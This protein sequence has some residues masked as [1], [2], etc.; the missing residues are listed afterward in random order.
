M[1]LY[2]LYCNVCKKKKFFDP[3]YSEYYEENAWMYWTQS[4]ITAFCLLCHFGQF[5]A[6]LV[7]SHKKWLFYETF[8]FLCIF[9][10]F[11]FFPFILLN[12]ER[13]INFVYS[14][15]MFPFVFISFYIERCRCGMLCEK[16]NNKQKL[17]FHQ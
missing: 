6:A 16:L 15:L 4:I 13:T 9:Y 3:S 14:S 17:N 1:Q 12:Y 5:R 8:N 7:L 10:S 11:I 2:S